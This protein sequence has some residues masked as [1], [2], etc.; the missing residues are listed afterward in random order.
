MGHIVGFPRSRVAAGGGGGVTDPTTITGCRFWVRGDDPSDFSGFSDTQAI[1]T[2]TNR[3]TAGGSIDQGTAGSKPRYRTSG[4]NG[5]P[6]IENDTTGKFL[7]SSQTISNYFSASAWTF[8]MVIRPQAAGPVGAQDWA[9]EGFIKDLDDRW[10]FGNASSKFAI[11]E[12]NSG[13]TSSIEYGSAYSTN[14]WYIVDVSFGGGTASLKVNGGTAVTGS[15][16]N[17]TS[18][19]NAMNIKGGGGINDW[20]EIT[21]FNV[22]ISGTDRDNYR[23]GL[24]FKYG[25]TIT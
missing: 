18:L 3:G 14:T 17:I 15:I 2:I 16:V 20:A 13:A 21:I 4:P 19:A 1:G 9:R 7:Q 25:I 5:K 22:Q 11:A 12:Y 24:A 10:Q 23:T 6:Y 8:F